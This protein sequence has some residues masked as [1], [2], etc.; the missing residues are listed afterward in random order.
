MVNMGGVKRLRP[1]PYPNDRDGDPWT[2]D[3]LDMCFS[4]TKGVVTACAHV[5][6][7]GGT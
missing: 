7:D 2:R 4:S 1:S 6:P 5:L 3:T